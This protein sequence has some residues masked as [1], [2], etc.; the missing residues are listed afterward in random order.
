MKGRNGRRNIGALREFRKLFGLTMEQMAALLNVSPAFY[1]K[2]EKGEGD[3]ASIVAFHAAVLM[4]LR[5]ADLLN[6]DY[7]TKLLIEKS[8]YPLYRLSHNIH[9]VRA[10]ESFA[11]LNKPS[12]IEK[13]HFSIRDNDIRSILMHEVYRALDEQETAA[14][15]AKSKESKKQDQNQSS[16]STQAEYA[17]P[18][19]RDGNKY[20]DLMLDKEGK[21]IDGIWLG[22]TFSALSQLTGLGATQ[23]SQ[24]TGLSRAF[25]SD[26]ENDR[27]S[28]VLTGSLDLTARAFK[29]TIDEFMYIALPQLMG[30]K[31][32]F[33]I[34]QYPQGYKNTETLETLTSSSTIEAFKTGNVKERAKMMLSYHTWL[35]DEA[36]ARVDLARTVFMPPALQPLKFAS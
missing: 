36:L 9:N 4:G 18:K 8:Y 16:V 21:L 28:S 3:P 31:W 34:H 35:E 5:L 30:T 27:S 12:S 20:I 23:L 14:A 7:S 32:P 11:A 2:F 24:R 26:L 1:A 33:F 25:F 29:L 22:E 13:E 17:I 10:V 6:L 19:P 15:R